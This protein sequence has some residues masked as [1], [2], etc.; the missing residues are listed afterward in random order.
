MN[1]CSSIEVNGVLDPQLR[2]CLIYP[3]QKCFCTIWSNANEIIF[4]D[5]GRG[6][7]TLCIGKLLNL[8]VENEPD[9]S[10][11]LK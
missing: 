8:V 2:F 3:Y 4:F 9:I 11:E 1:W 5:I 7:H 6:W 10:A